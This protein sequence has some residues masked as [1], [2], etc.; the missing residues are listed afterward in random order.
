MVFLAERW[1]FWECKRQFAFKIVSPFERGQ[2]TSYLKNL[3]LFEPKKRMG[4]YLSLGANMGDLNEPYPL[5]KNDIY[6]N[7]TEM[8]KTSNKLKNCKKGRV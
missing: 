1:C 4:A 7:V 6:I 3:K 8:D 2:Q 5:K